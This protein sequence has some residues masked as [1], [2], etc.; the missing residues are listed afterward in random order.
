[1]RAA[2][3]KLVVIAL[4]P[5]PSTVAARPTCT[6]QAQRLAAAELG[7]GHAEHVA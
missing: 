2:R 1:M 6:V 4:S 5:M 7:P 3:R